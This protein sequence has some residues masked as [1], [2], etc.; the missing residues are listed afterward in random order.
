MLR[1]VSGGIRDGIRRE[2]GSALKLT[3]VSA[4]YFMYPLAFG[5]DAFKAWS[6]SEFFVVVALVL[7]M[8]LVPVRV[9][10]WPQRHTVRHGD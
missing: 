1:A 6:W 4:S 5:F 10:F 9:C 7:G 8:S 2:A 3:L